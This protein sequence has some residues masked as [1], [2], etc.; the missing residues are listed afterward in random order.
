MIMHESVKRILKKIADLEVR[1]I[2]LETA[3][4]ELQSEIAV[5][6]ADRDVNGGHYDVNGTQ[7]ATNGTYHSV[8]GNLTGYES[9]SNGS[10][11]DFTV[12][13]GSTAMSHP[14]IRNADVVIAAQQSSVDLHELRS[15]IGM[16]SEV[17]GDH[18][19]RIAQQSTR[20]YELDQSFQR[21]DKTS[22][23]LQG[24]IGKLE[25]DFKGLDS[26][27][28][29]IEV[30]SNRGRSLSKTGGSADVGAYLMD[31]VQQMQ[32]RLADLTTSCQKGYEE[33]EG[34]CTA[35][36]TVVEG[37]SSETVGRVEQWQTLAN[38]SN[39]DDRKASKKDVV[40]Y[41]AI[42]NL[43]HYLLT[44]LIGG[45]ETMAVRRAQNEQEQASY[46]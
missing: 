46:R 20:T 5:L 7:C 32:M 29:E 23:W 25:K 16:I 6:K 1:C 22:T 45:P 40:S 41:P 28:D 27:V 19:K 2:G 36:A 8:N 4:K 14:L 34:K 15:K 37:G 12:S 43:H 42:L 3:N 13:S 11:R 31:E 39:K 33:L 24:R 38:N 18:E 44:L 26:K 17:L 35:L 30:D 9:S 10:E 21:K